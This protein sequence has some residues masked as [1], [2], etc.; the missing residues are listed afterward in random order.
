MK[1]QAAME[2]LMTY[3]WAVVVVVAVIITVTYVHV[4]PNN[5][6]EGTCELQGDFKCQD[7]AMDSSGNVRFVLMSGTAATI[8]SATVSDVESTQSCG[9]DNLDILTSS[10]RVVQP[11]KTEQYPGDK[12]I[13]GL[14]CND[15][16]VAS[17]NRYSGTIELTYR[18]SSGLVKTVNGKLQ[19]VRVP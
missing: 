3:G 15:G 16:V 5:Y 14:L 1:A 11:L 18:A 10:S 8:I 9:F 6:L 7:V 2:F 17:N 13:V 19:N 4:S 12:N